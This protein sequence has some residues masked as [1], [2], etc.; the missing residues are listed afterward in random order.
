[1]LNKQ[2]HFMTKNVEHTTHE[3]F[4]CK[5]RQLF[6]FCCLHFCV[7]ISNF[8]GIIALDENALLQYACNM[9]SYRIDV[10][11]SLVHHSNSCF[12]HINNTP[13][14]ESENDYTRMRH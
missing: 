1:M 12:P 8:S 9:R 11:E 7:T 10:T 6:L 14:S 13:H 2:K 5:H 3:Y 4:D